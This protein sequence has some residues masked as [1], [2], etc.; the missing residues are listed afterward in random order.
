MDN[1]VT[2]GMKEI[3]I[4]MLCLVLYVT[5]I[6]IFEGRADIARQGQLVE[7]ETSFTYIPPAPPIT[8]DGNTVVVDIDN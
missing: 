6:E 8:D 4:L 2:I 1:Q 5:A 3:I 7:Q